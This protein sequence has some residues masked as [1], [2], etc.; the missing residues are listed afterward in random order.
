MSSYTFKQCTRADETKIVDFL[1]TIKDELL[2]PDREAISNMM[3]FIF[4]HGGVIAAYDN[5][6]L[7][8]MLGFFYGEPAHEFSNRH[9]AFLY[10]AGI[11]P[12]YRLS[13][14]FHKGLLFAL[15]KLQAMGLREI[16]MQAEAVNPY[17]NKLYARFADFLYRDK[18]LRDTVAAVALMEKN[19][20]TIA[21]S[22]AIV[23]KVLDRQEARDKM[24]ME[25][26]LEA[27][28]LRNHKETN[29]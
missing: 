3:A 5:D 20:V 22:Q 17:T 12:Q 25:L 26:V 24:M 16:R 2:L 21:S 11:A 18:T 29:K 8:G 9:V 27:T 6:K 23:A 7:C 1:V 28:R 4:A 10:V 14:V 13:R 15:R 19:Q